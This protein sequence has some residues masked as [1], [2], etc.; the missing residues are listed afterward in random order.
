MNFMSQDKFLHRES[1][2][3]SPTLTDFKDN[4]VLWQGHPSHWLYLGRYAF[5]TVLWLTNA[6]TAL[7]WYAENDYLPMS[8]YFPILQAM[9]ISIALVAPL[10]ILW[11]FLWLRSLKTV[12]TTNEIIEYTGIFSWT[13]SKK[14]CDLAQVIDASEMPPG[15]SVL[16]VLGFGHVIISTADHDQ[17]I[18]T[19]RAIK[20]YTLVCNLVRELRRKLRFERREYFGQ[21]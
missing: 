16:G 18:I 15:F 2:H 17:P 4:T 3:P 19:L 1:Q 13:R 21:P 10:M 7:S 5:Y 12:I 20:D 9:F 6:I 11:Q 14:G 8:P